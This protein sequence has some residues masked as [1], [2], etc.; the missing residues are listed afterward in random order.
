MHLVQHEPYAFPALYNLISSFYHISIV[1][2]IRGGIKMNPCN[3][4]CYNGWL[5]KEPTF[6]K[7]KEGIEFQARFILKVKRDYR[8][9]DGKYEYDYI[10]MRISGETRLKI[11]RMM[12]PGDSLAICGSVRTGRYEIKGKSCYEVYINVDSVS[13]SPR[14]SFFAGEKEEFPNN[15]P[16]KEEAADTTIISGFDLPFH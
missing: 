16:Q 5:L 6:I 2:V 10:P 12:N 14:A 15:K 4:G 1:D 9:R 7:N 11:A 3:N 8:G 13:Y